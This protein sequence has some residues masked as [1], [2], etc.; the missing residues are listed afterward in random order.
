MFIVTI[1]CL[2]ASVAG[3]WVYDMSGK[4]W[5]VYITTLKEAA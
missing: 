2:L 3:G 1:T 4:A 5:A